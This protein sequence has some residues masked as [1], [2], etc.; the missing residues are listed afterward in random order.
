MGETLTGLLLE[1]LFSSHLIKLY[2][3]VDNIIDEGRQ[4]TVIPISKG[5]HNHVVENYWRKH[6]FGHE[7]T[8]LVNE[9]PHQQLPARKQN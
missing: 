7:T 3:T 2:A 4:I 1:I 5:L 6:F 9:R 8:V